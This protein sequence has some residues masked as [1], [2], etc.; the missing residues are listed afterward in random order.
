MAMMFGNVRALRSV[1]SL[2]GPQLEDFNRIMG[3]MGERAGA[4]EKAYEKMADSTI[5]KVE[6]LSNTWKSIGI[7]MWEKVNPAFEDVVGVLNS[8]G[9]GIKSLID[10]SYK[11]RDM[12]S[13]LDEE[14]KNLSLAIDD[15]G[16]KVANANSVVSR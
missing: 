14:A 16:E 7:L 15:V 11:L 6:T 3:E 2:T 9:L 1:L 4:T 10:D 8:L 5:N 13:D 12:F